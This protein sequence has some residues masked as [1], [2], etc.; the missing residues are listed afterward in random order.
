MRAIL[1]IPL[2]VLALGAYHLVVFDVVALPQELFAVPMMSGATF[3]LTVADAIVLGALVLLFVELL[4]ATQTSSRTL[5]EHLLSTL[6]F[7]AALVEF[8]LVPKA[9]TATFLIL[10]LLCLIDVVAGYSISIRVARRDL[11]VGGDGGL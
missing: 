6:V 11:T 9:A 1:V 10:T 7:I 2:L 5:V 4:K 3:T 8:L